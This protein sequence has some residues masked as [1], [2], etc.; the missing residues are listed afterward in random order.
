M[1]LAAPVTAV[2]LATLLAEIEAMAVPG[3]VLDV[4]G[5]VLGINAAAAR[6]LVRPPSEVVGRMAWEF[7]P[8]FE[9]VWAERIEV[10]RGSSGRTFEIAI[11]TPRGALMLEYVLAVHEL[12]GQTLVV[13]SVITSRPLT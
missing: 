6:L 9:Y 13:A 10:A 2:T 3:A 4:G 5:K 1:L 7:A 11:A 8:G 12:A